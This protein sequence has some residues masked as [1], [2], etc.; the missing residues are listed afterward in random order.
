LRVLV[1]RLWPRG[2]TK[3]S[4]R[5]DTWVKDVAPSNELRKRFHHDVSQWEE[6]RTQYMAYLRGHRPQLEQL[7]TQAAKAG[8]LTLVYSAK[9]TDH[10]NAVVLRDV[11]QEIQRSK[12]HRVRRAA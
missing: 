7:L 12:G 11:L 10:N 4:L 9:E 1:D 3:E 5:L 8:T 6:F 2:V